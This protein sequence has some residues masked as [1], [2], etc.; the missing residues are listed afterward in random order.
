MANGRHG[1]EHPW[2]FSSLR[3]CGVKVAIIDSGIDAS[4][5]KVKPVSSGVQFRTSAYDQVV[6]SADSSDC[7]GHGTACAGIIRKKAPDA[8]IYS[9]RI[10]DESLRASD[11]ALITALRWS[12]D[13]GMDVVNL[14][15]GSVHSSVVDELRKVC[16]EAAAG[17]AILVSA[18]HNEGRE[19][20]PAIFPEVIGVEGGQV[21]GDYGYLFRAG[22]AIE[23]VA[24][25]DE[26]RLCW[27]NQSEIMAGGTSFAAPHI[28]GIV[29]LILEAEPGADLNRV[30]EVLQENALDAQPGHTSG[31]G[32]PGIP[33]SDCSWKPATP[34]NK[35]AL[36]R[37]CRA[38]IYPFNKEMHTF[39]RFH[40]QL[41]FELVGIADPPARGLVGQD[42]GEAIGI[43]TVGIRISPRLANALVDADTLILGYVDQISRITRRD[44]LEESVR[45]AIDRGVNVFSF[46]PL[47][48]EIH[49]RLRERASRKNLRISYPGISHAEVEE[50]FGRESRPPTDVPVLGVFGT[51]SHQGKFTVQVALRKQL[52]RMGY[53]V[54][55]IGTEHQSELFGMDYAF[56]IGYASPLDLPLQFHAP[57]IEA[58]IRELAASRRPD[59]IIVGSQSGTVPFDVEESETHSL[60]S[61]AFLLGTQPDACILVVNSIDPEPYIQD[62]IDA[63]RT[64]G[65]APVILLAMSDKEK[66]IRVAYQRSWVAPR[67]MSR[68]EVARSLERLETRFGLPAVEIVSETGQ[69][70][71]TDVVV[72]HFARERAA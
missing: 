55:Q 1:S 66:Q 30:R 60:P 21:R 4:H 40:D 43:P 16:M 29:A 54:G 31:E 3:G 8:R 14:S 35:R 39:V 61:I 17:G 37:I 63:I 22:D 34:F 62:T 42:A 26:Q 51:S 56:P 24:R 52:R 27:L 47:S 36:P 57:F 11:Q 5:A 28:S 69:R 49:G 15:L 67:Q 44:V 32:S 9:V 71:M 33:P 53:N 68:A 50:L 13:K 25:G 41:D 6:E 72:Q 10:F 65:Q 23:C 38:A 18:A 12:T 20:Y 64:I 46:L 19:S 70:R 7:V 58:K 48:P 45:L 59:L 2:E